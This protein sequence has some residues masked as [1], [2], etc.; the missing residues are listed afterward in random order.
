M[1]DRLVTGPDGVT[2]CWWP[3]DDP[4]YISYHDTEW[5]YPVTDDQAL[6]RK[7]SLDAFQAGLSWITILRKREAFRAAFDDF[8]IPTVAGYGP[9]DV[10]RLLHDPGIVRHR[11][12]IEAT[13]RNAEHALGLIAEFGSLSAYLAGFT[14]PPRPAPVYEIPA[15]TEESTALAADLRRR[16]WSFVGPTVA[17]AFMQAVGMVN[18]H[19]EGCEIR[20]DVEQAR[21]AAR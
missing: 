6:F 13:I 20:D 2:R 18:D 15:A 10:Q 4:L 5:G 12:K 1:H 3:G 16:G 11:G 9:E 7:L 14:P 19:L 8:D 17:Y 21:Q